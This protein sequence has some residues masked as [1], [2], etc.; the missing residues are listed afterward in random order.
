MM[1]KMM[2]DMGPED[3]M[4]KAFKLFDE[5]GTGKISVANLR[6]LC[7]ASGQEIEA[8]ELNDIIDVCSDGKEA[9][10]LS[11]FIRVMKSQGLCPL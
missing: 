8:E 6:S 3:E 11:D 2:Q 4:K 9:I 7:E 10:L 5:D 1:K